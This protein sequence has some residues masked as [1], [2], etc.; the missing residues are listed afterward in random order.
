[1]TEQGRGTLYHQ[2]RE[3]VNR[4]VIV[5][6]G[7]VGSTYAYSLMISGLVSEIIIIDV[8]EERAMGEVMDLNHGLPFVRPAVIRTGTYA[9]CATADLVVVTAGAAQKEGET[10]IDLVHRNTE[11]F[12]NIVPQIMA[13][14]TQAVL[15]IATNPVD[16][17]TYVTYKLSGL[18]KQKV[19]GS[20]TVLDTARFRYLLSEHCRIDPSNV[21]GYILGEHG[22]SELPVWSLANIAGLRFS[23]YCPVC[24]KNCGPLKKEEIFQEVKNAA[25]RIIKGKGAT[26]YAIGLAL[27][28]IT[29]SILRNE[30][31]VLT[32][33]TYLEGE[34]GLEDVC[35]SLPTVVA[36]SGAQ[37]IITLTLDEKEEAMLKHSAAVLKKVI[38]ELDL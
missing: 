7:M 11:I 3:R 15:L 28:N 9:D 20:G 19:I 12:K 34:Y 21:H 24:G 26:Y 31:S 29:E 5:G 14:G 33:S 16:I 23:E 2:E 4:V 30:F 37:K 1:M 25:Y 18:P 13:S 22:D 35:L 17:M 10:R 8:N 32:V 36:R 27:V 38:A 6:A